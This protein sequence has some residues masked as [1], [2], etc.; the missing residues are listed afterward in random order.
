MSRSML[1]NRRRALGFTLIELLVVIAIIAVL[2][3]L[4]LPAVQQAREAARR[5]QCKNNLKQIGL[6]LHNYH[7][8]FNMFPPSTVTISGSLLPSWGW[9]AFLLPSID[10]APLYQKLNLTTNRLSTGPTTVLGTP[11][12]QTIIPAF[13][14]PSDTGPNL[15]SQKRNHAKSNYRSLGGA[16]PNVVYGASVP[17]SAWDTFNTNGVFSV[18]SRTRMADITDGTSNTLQVAE[19]ELRDP[20]K[21]GA[22]W[23]GVTET[24][25][26]FTISD[27]MWFLNRNEWRINGIALQAPSSRH[28][29]GTHFLLTDGS[30]RFISENVDGLTLESAATRAGGE[31]LGDF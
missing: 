11:D 21:N 3:A 6:A 15:N 2:I 19:V 13:I 31:V 20:V 7:D 14:C 4:L 26:N 23:V 28:T 8:L 22:I 1:P 24:S 9:P 29:G 27:V 12:T 17:Q 18:N 30:V 10:Q 16:A 25:P 5:T